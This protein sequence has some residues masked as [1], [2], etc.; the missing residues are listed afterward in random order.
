MSTSSTTPII[1]VTEE[2]RRRTGLIWVAGGAALLLGGSTFAL[3]SATDVFT[4]GTITAGDLDLVQAAD[5]TFWD[6]S[7]DRRDA[8]ATVTGT[9]GTQPG[10]AISPVDA[11]TW[12][13]VPGDKVSASF[14]AD[15]TLEGDNLVGLLSLDG[16]EAVDSGIT[17][18]SYSYEVYQAGE[19]VV[20]ETALPTVAGAP[21]LYLS[22][23]GTG[24]DSGAED[25]TATGPDG[26]AAATTVFP[27]D[28]E[29]EDLTV[30]VYG[31]FFVDGDGD[32]RYTAEG[33]DSTAT[34][35]T[36]VTAS[37]TLADL[38]LSIEQVRGTGAQAVPAGS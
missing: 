36:D 7:S 8:S 3:W 14:S 11:S 4:G 35:R 26:G 21:L 19:I 28:L 18:V 29:T 12:R 15:V 16:L 5:T 20:E 32:F 23:P 33:V 30:V 31:S 10:H 17:G 6:V 13:M 1:V 9:D 38:T 24:Q 27:M 2:N 25:A 37:D 22:A 34:D